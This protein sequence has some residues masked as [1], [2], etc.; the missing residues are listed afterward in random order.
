M[1][2]KAIVA[3]QN[4]EEE[5]FDLHFSMNGGDQFYLKPYLDHYLEGN[6]TKTLLEIKS[7]KPGEIDELND[8]EEWVSEHDHAVKPRPRETGVPLEEIGTHIDFLRIE[9]LYLVRENTVETYVPVWVYPD[10]LRALREMVE[11]T[12]FPLDAFDRQTLVAEGADPIAEFTEDDFAS[13]VIEQPRIRRF[14]EENHQGILQT[15]EGQIRQAT[16]E[17]DLDRTGLVMN[18]VVSI[19]PITAEGALPNSEGR[20]I[21][22]EV[23]YDDEAEEPINQQ[24]V[25]TTGQV[26]RLQQAATLIDEGYPSPDRLLRAELS[27]LVEVIRRYGDRVHAFGTAPYDEYVDSYFDRLGV[28]AKSDGAQYRVMELEQDTV[29]L[30]KRDANGTTSEKIDTRVVEREGPTEQADAVLGRLSQGDIVRAD[31][32]QDSSP[33]RFT[34][35][36]FDH[37]CPMVM[38]DADVHPEVVE[39]VYE[40]ELTETEEPTEEPTS[41]KIVVPSP[42]ESVDQESVHIAEAYIALDPTEEHWQSAISGEL[43]VPMSFV[44]FDGEPTEIIGCNPPSTPYWYIFTFQTERSGL[45]QELREQMDAPYV[46]LTSKL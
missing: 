26:H 1:P 17:A 19:D 8:L 15:V 25:V 6:L 24:A 9:A 35:I 30:A 12:V 13:D 2:T 22:V 31:I 36:S 34:S 10:S 32:D 46:P 45:A 33:A 37:H 40:E 5:T 4:E 23:E 28:T 20:G 42:L 16:T 43:T 21:F 39:Q 41:L 29:R 18:E 14:L 27:I 7:K 11:L 38:S 3:Y 44:H